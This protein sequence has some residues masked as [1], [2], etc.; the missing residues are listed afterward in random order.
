LSLFWVAWVTQ[1][2]SPGYYIILLY[3]WYQY[4]PNTHSCVDLHETNDTSAI[5]M[6]YVYECM[7]LCVFTHICIPWS[8]QPCI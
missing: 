8:C 3:I 6:S 5:T 7:Y 1:T 4:V 2:S